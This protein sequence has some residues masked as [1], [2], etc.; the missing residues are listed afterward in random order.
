[1]NKIKLAFSLFCLSIFTL[2]AQS[3]DALL[4]Y[5]EYLDEGTLGGQHWP[6]DERKPETR[7]HSFKKVFD[8]FEE[9]GGKIVVEL[10][11]SRS[12]THGGHP[13]CNKDNKK[14]WMP[15][16]P[17]FWDWG[18]GFFTRM[19]CECLSHLNPEIHTVDISARHINRCKHMTADFKPYLK[20]HVASS[21][22]FLKRCRFKNGIDLLY[23]DTGDIT[24]I[25]PTAKLHLAEAKI[26]V[27]RDLIAPNGMILIDDV[28]NQTPRLYGEKSKLGKAKYSIPY[29]LQNGFEIVMDEYQVILRKK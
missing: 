18:A 14:Y 28:R 24:P 10:G 13:G 23:L 7:Y 17:E 25:E 4:Q 2:C 8:H 29:F 9:T 3:S 19:A 1:M 27:E 11:T 6:E 16:S 21:L 20:Y 12:F 22:T 26:I 15:D 5:K